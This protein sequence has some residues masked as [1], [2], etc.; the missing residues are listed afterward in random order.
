[1][2][3]IEL[4]QR[5]LDTARHEAGHVLPLLVHNIP[6]K[7]VEILVHESVDITTVPNLGYV[8][9]DGNLS[10]GLVRTDKIAFILQGCRFACEDQIIQALAGV[11]GEQIEYEKP[12]WNNR[13]WKGRNARARFD[14]EDAKELASRL[15]IRSLRPYFRQA[16]ELLQQHKA[17]HTAIVAALLDKSLLTY[18]E[19]LEIWRAQ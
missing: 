1:M 19:C 6:F 13:D 15:A 3:P 4:V 14:Y 17:K 7:N 18:T 10:L 8:L 9:E 12:I 2:K 5:R 11:A 16:W